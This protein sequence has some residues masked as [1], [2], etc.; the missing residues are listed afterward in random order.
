[1]AGGVVPEQIAVEVKRQQN[2]PSV[3]HFLVKRDSQ[4]VINPSTIERRFRTTERNTVVQSDGLVDAFQDGVSDLQVMRVEPTSDSLALEAIVKPLR[5][6]LVS[7]AIRDESGVEMDRTK[8]G[9]EVRDL[10]VPYAAA[11]KE[12][13]RKPV[14]ERQQ[15]VKRNCRRTQVH[16]ALKPGHRSQVI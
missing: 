2:H 4:L 3:S 15:C 1:M 7:V 11:A 5:E 16:D 13:Y 6:E 9:A 14:L 10:L 8:L 12:C